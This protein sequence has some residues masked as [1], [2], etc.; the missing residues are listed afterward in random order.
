[1]NIADALDRN[2]TFFSEGTPWC[3]AGRS[4]PVGTFL[5]QGRCGL[6]S[7]GTFRRVRRLVYWVP[8]ES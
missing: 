1:M 8:A 6:S 4:G 5:P 3:L 7:P 2:G